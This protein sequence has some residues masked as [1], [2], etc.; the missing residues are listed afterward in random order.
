MFFVYDYVVSYKL[1]VGKAIWALKIK[2][3]LKGD[4]A[5]NFC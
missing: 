3:H 1:D 2:K 4:L 5:I